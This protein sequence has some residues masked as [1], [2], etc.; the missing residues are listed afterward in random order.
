MDREAE[1]IKQQMEQTRASLSE[2][3]ETL[4]QQVVGTVQ[5]ATTKVAHTVDTVTEAVQETV[6]TVKESL[7]ETMASVKESLDLCR[8]V[9]QHPWLMMGGAVCTGYVGER[10]LE[11]IDGRRLAALPPQPRHFL[12]GPRRT[13]D[14]PA[15]GL[16]PEP[17][18]PERHAEPSWLTLLTN[19]FGPE[20][21]KL[22]SVA[23]GTAMGLVRDRIAEATPPHLQSQ[24]T[25]L[26]DSV[27]L[28]LGGEPTPPSPSSTCEAGR[29]NGA[30]T[31]RPLGT[32]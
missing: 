29:H 19:S 3:L 22:K 15:S 16:A 10:L 26:L 24:V 23:I 5:G 27:T 4:E 25:E 30:G 2:K 14:V 17:A 18:P 31:G 6:A 8:Q 20:I 32:M 21:A 1:V 11:R 9:E 12:G 28:K 13:P 7:E